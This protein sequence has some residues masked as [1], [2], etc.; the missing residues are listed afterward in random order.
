MNLIKNPY[1]RDELDN[2][3]FQFGNKALL[4][5][6][7]YC[8][9]FN[10]SRKTASRHIKRRGVHTIKIGIDVF[11]PILDL[12]LYLARKRAVQEGRLII[13]TPSEDEMK[14][15]R[16]FAKK[17]HDEKLAGELP[18]GSILCFPQK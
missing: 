18:D 17:A 11:I 2:L 14:N 12:A 10:V 7:D 9:L 16:G 5:L 1:V 4:T 6:D 15:Q 13:I 3:E 8:A